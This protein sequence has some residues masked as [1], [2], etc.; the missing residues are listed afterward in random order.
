M[1]VYQVTLSGTAD[2]ALV[3]PSG[4]V[5]LDGG[6]LNLVASQFHLDR[7]HVNRIVLSPEAALDPA[8]DVVLV[9]GDLRAV[10]Q[11][12]RHGTATGALKIGGQL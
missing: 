6:T 3:Q 9:S 8:I 11:V 7:E 4:V 2:P 5:R 1:C 10:I 12:R